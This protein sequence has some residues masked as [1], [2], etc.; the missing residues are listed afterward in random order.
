M[1]KK[2]CPDLAVYFGGFDLSER[3]SKER[4]KCLELEKKVGLDEVEEEDVDSVGVDQQG[5]V[6]G[7]AKRTGEAAASVGGGGGVWAAPYS[8]TDEEDDRQ[9]SAGLLWGAEPGTGPHG[10]GGPRL[11]TGG[12]YEA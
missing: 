7:G 2:L 12:T 6:N 11:Q 9:D 10:H 5:A 4:L 1:W 8:S 3:L